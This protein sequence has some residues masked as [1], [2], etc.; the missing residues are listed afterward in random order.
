MGGQKQGAGGQ[1]SVSSISLD[2]AEWTLAEQGPSEN[3]F[4]NKA[5][6]VVGVEL[7]TE[8]TAFRVDFDDLASLRSNI[9]HGFGGAG[10]ISADVELFGGANRPGADTAATADATGHLEAATGHPAAAPAIKGMAIITKLPQIPHGMSYNGLIFLPF[11]DFSYSLYMRFEEVGVTGMRDAVILDLLM[12]SGDV[13][14]S[15][16]TTPPI[17]SGLSE[18]LY[19][20]TLRGPLVRSKA[21]REEYDEKFPDHPLSKLRSCMRR[22]KQALIIDP[23]VMQAEQGS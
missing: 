9:R 18:D 6:D 19:D 23:V 3:V 15:T 14:V 11:R 4:V 21:E 13:T 7:R 22:V 10:L 17:I 16:H 12:Q 2:A 8:A 5:G 20:P 1:I